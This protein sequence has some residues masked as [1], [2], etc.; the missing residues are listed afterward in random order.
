MCKLSIF[1]SLAV[2]SSS[3]SALVE[4]AGGVASWTVRYVSNSAFTFLSVGTE[5]SLLQAAKPNTASPAN[6]KLLIS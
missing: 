1:W 6:N 2:V 4:V 5:S 3:V